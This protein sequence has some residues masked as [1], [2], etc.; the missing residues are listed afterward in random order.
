MPLLLQGQGKT[1]EITYLGLRSLRLKAL[2]ILELPQNE[3]ICSL[4]V[5]ENI[6]QRWCLLVAIETGQGFITGP[7]QQY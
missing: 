4:E 5:A 1:L 6:K 7:R 2:A 3:R